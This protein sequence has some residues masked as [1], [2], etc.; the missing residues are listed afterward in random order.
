MPTNKNISLALLTLYMSCEEK[1]EFIHVMKRHQDL[2][3]GDLDLL[4]E[5]INSAYGRGFDNNYEEQNEKRQKR[6]I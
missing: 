3:S 6:V 2:Y 4:W 5:I 1:S